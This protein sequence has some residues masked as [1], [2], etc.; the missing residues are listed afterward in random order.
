MGVGLA[1]A[2]APLA[3]RSVDLH[4]GDVAGVEEP[5]QPGPVGPGALDAGE[6]HRAKALEP[7]E[8]FGVTG[9][10]RGELLDA[11]QGASFV[12]RRSDVDIEVGVDTRGDP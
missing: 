10:C 9:G 2:A 11:E 12:K 8:Q 7:A 1:A 3:V 4:D 6:L 5:G